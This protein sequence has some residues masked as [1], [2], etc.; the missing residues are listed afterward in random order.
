MREL[1]TANKRRSPKNSRHV[2]G[3]K[4][5][6]VIREMIAEEDNVSVHSLKLDTDA[7]V[8]ISVNERGNEV[9]CDGQPYLVQLKRWKKIE[10]DLI[11]KDGTYDISKIPEVCDNIKF[12][13][14][15]S[16]ELINEERLRL[17]ELSQLLCR[18]IVP[19]EYGVTSDE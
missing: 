11:K 14:L 17:L 4:P 3:L 5:E 8:G 18:V 10:N 2:T 12:D 15:H 16:P 7:T 9:D 6:H 13:L 19:M 1:E